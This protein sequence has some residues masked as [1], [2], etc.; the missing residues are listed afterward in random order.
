MNDPNWVSEVGN[1]GLNFMAEI[2]INDIKLYCSR[3]KPICWR[4]S[5]HY[6]DKSLSCDSAFQDVF[7]YI[8]FIFQKW[9]KHETISNISKTYRHHAKYHMYIWYTMIYIIEILMLFHWFVENRYNAVNF[10]QNHHNRHPI[11]RPNAE[12]WGVFVI[13]NFYFFV[14]VY[15]VMHTI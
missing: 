2:S 5:L 9:R 15:A 7:I 6:P 4:Q 11:Y 8:S 10:Y 3:N 14:S 13:T 1:Y 12:V